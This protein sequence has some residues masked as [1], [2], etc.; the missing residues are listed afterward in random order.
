MD[1]GQGEHV[2]WMRLWRSIK[3]C[4]MLSSLCLFCCGAGSKVEFCYDFG[5]LM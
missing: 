3:V 4:R 2:L 5:V 1:L